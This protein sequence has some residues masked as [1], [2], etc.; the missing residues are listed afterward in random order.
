MSY[1]IYLSK[2]ILTIANKNSFMNLKEA[3]SHMTVAKHYVPV[4]GYGGHIS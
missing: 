2:S 4:R 1:A 3:I